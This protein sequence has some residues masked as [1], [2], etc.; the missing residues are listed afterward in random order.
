MPAKVTLTVIQG[1]LQGKEFLFD[2]R[3]TCLIGRD[4]DCYPQAG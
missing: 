4:E 3:D 1:P 2:E